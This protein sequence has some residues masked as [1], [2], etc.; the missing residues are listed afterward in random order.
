VSDVERRTPPDDA[1]LLRLCERVLAA[2]MN[3]EEF[4]AAFPWTQGDGF[5]EAVW[6]D[7][8]DAVY[9]APGRLFRKGI[10]HDAYRESEPYLVVYLE[11]EL[12]RLGLERDQ[13]LAV[14][15]SVI[16]QRELSREL[17][18]QRLQSAARTLRGKTM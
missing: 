17:I 15:R 11:C 14:R 16:D 4:H 8:R 2:D 5:V 7:L 13:I 9:H 1:T 18:E 6:L 10:D 3:S 12:L